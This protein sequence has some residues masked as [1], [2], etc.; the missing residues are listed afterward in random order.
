MPSH[1]QAPVPD[2]S[3]PFASSVEDRENG[4][5]VIMKSEE[6]YSEESDTK[7]VAILYAGILLAA[8]II[9]IYGLLN[10]FWAAAD[11]IERSTRVGSM[12]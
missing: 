4:G 12:F 10:L 1:R 9:G 8:F 7:A 11:T 3:D 5:E 6:I 2:K